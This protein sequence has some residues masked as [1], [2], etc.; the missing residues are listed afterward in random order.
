[1]L[2]T[3]H[4]KANTFS[5][6]IMSDL[7]HGNQH[8]HF[9]DNVKYSENLGIRTY[10]RFFKEVSQLNQ[11]IEYCTW[12]SYSSSALRIY[13]LIPFTF[14][15]EHLPLLH[16]IHSR[17]VSVLILYQSQPFFFFPLIVSKIL[18]CNFTTN[19]TWADLQDVHCSYNYVRRLIC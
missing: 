8:L 4:K 9:S 15:D 3:E 2:L 16:A 12:N 19:L 10:S 11:S 17:C 13:F 18:W 6:A 7:K 14:W 1:M 5:D